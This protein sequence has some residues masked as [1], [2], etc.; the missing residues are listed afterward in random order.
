MVGAAS[1]RR[2][3]ATA[4]LLALVAAGVPVVLW[5]RFS[6]PLWY[7]EL[8]RP[9]FVAEP[10]ATFWSELATANV[11]SAVGWVALVRALGASL[12]WHAWALRLPAAIA[13]VALVAATYLF[14]RRFTGVAAAL[15]AALAVGLSGTMVDLATQ[16]KPY[17]LEAVCSLA[18]VALWTDRRSVARRTAAGGV[19]L[20]SLPAVFLIIPMAVADVVAAPGRRLR[21]ALAATPALALAGGHAVLFV[22]HQSSQRL[23]SFWDDH[24]LTDRAVTDGA[25]FV[26]GELGSMAAGAPPGID[27]EDPNLVH[28]VV[29]TSGVAGWAIGVAVAIAFVVGVA[30]LHRRPGGPTLLIALVGAEALMLAASA[31]RYWPFGAVR[32]NV[33]VVPLLTVVVAVGAAALVGWVTGWVTGRLRASPGGAGRGHYRRAR[34]PKRVPR[35]IVVG[36]T[37]VSVGVAAVP[38]AAATALHPVWTERDDTR[39]TELMVDA[40]IAARRLYRPGDMLLVGGRL[41]RP[42][43]LYGME[44]SEDGPFADDDLGDDDR[45]DD[46][47]AS[48]AA[49]PGAVGPRV[50]RAETVFLTAVDDDTVG[51]ALAAGAPEA[52]RRVLLFVLD[53]DRRGTG[54]ALAEAGAAGWCTSREHRFELTGTLYVLV[55]CGA[56]TIPGNR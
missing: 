17:T 29:D 49:A 33:F 43:W 44:I 12:G 23:S 18:V 15:G 22:L 25:R 19:A 40:T 53:Y 36:A 54:E 6:R 51:S 16:L 34:A 46:G 31:G 27:H 9:H 20:F 26:L 55:R 48:E 21:A 30:V 5:T 11:P 13:F 14:S 47:F 56:S 28:P 10:A 38:V 32:T 45:T 39:P 2:D 1:G 24:F 7:D 4:A 52:D 3:L 50:S 37:M 41:A 35:T 8:W 42:G